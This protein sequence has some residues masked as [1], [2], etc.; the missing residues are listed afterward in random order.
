MSDNSIM[1]TIFLKHDQSKR[2]EEINKVTCS[3]CLLQ[4]SGES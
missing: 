2:L 3:H 4:L 1:L